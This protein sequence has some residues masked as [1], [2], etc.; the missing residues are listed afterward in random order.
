M[1]LAAALGHQPLDRVDVL[2]LAKE[3]YYGDAPD[4]SGGNFDHF[5]RRIRVPVRG[6]T[7]ARVARMNGTLLH[8]LT[9]VFTAD[10]TA[11][12]SPSELQEGVAQY[13]EGKRSD[14]FRPPADDP[15]AE[16]RRRYLSALLFTEYL[17]QQGGLST[18]AFALR[19]TGRAGDLQKGF[20]AAYNRD[21]AT[22][23]S[24]WER[25]S[26]AQGAVDGSRVR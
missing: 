14:S 11:D 21:Y 4:W 18:L 10:A 25:Q 8:E 17:V 15:Y 1:T 23:Q 13:M 12:L 24:E 5:D 7:E 20:L 6:L 26:A 22:L 3:E 19:E 9:H 2:L 16:V